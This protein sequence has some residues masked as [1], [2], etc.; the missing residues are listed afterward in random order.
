MKITSITVNGYVVDEK[1]LKK[2]IQLNEKYSLGLEIMEETLECE[3]EE[4][5]MKRL[6]LNDKKN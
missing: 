3:M 2:L 5:L 6:T 4:E 1:D